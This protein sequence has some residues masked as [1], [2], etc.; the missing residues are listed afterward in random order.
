MKNFTDFMEASKT[1]PKGKYYCFTEKKCKPL[2]RGY[3]IG[4]GGR[5]APDNRSDS[6]NG[7]TLTDTLTGMGITGMVVEM[8]TVVMVAM[9]VATAVVEMVVN[10]NK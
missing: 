5:L 10:K 3:R 9:V 4:Y 7:K 8:V 6:G 1:C 2:P